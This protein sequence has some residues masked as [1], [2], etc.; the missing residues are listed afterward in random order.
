MEGLPAEMIDR[1]SAFHHMSTPFFVSFAPFSVPLRGSERG[2]VI[3]VI[4]PPMW[5]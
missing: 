1:D 2:V 5:M 3:A 4:N